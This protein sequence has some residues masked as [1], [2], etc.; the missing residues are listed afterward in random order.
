MFYLCFLT[1]LAS[2]DYT[3][4]FKISGPSIFLYICRLFF[5]AEEEFPDVIFSICKVFYYLS[6]QSLK[7][8]H[9]FDDHVFVLLFWMHLGFMCVAHSFYSCTH[10][11]EP[12]LFSMSKFVP[13]FFVEVPIFWAPPG[14]FLAP[15][16]HVQNFIHTIFLWDDLD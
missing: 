1:S 4:D 2:G 8:M 7:F 3:L 16:H 15:F 6:V 5:F 10:C 9:S 14:H 11:I 13:N 12:I